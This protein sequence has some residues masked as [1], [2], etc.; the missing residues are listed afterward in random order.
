MKEKVVHVGFAKIFYMTN[1]SYEKFLHQP[2]EL[3]YRNVTIDEEMNLVH[4]AEVYKVNW[5]YLER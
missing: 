4:W 5:T 2:F 3:L 1:E